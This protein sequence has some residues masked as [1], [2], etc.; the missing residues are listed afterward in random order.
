MLLTDSYGAGRAWLVG[1]AAHQNPPW[2]GHGFNTGVGD[3]VNLAWKLAAVLHGWATPALLDTY[4]TERRPVAQQTIDLA[5]TNLRALSVDMSSPELMHEGDNGVRARAAAAIAI[6]D[7]KRAEFYSLGLVLGYGYG[8]TSPDQA[9]TMDVYRPIVAVGNR[10]PHS[11]DAAGRSLYDLLG[12]EFTLLGQPRADWKQ[13][14]E[15]RDIPLVVVDPVALGFAPV[16]DGSLVL[17]RP[18]Q[19]IAWIGGTSDDPLS[20]FDLALNL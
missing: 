4:E 16:A 11:R 7:V 9:P 20:A 1:D 5:A 18:D 6:E 13:A 19:H 15:A 10:L 3:A 12:P 14:A 8:P 17:I 2:G